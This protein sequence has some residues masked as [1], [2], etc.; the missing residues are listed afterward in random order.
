MPLAPLDQ[1][2]VAKGVAHGRSQAFPAIN[3]E[4]EP[5]RTGEAPLL[6]LLEKGREHGL[7]FGSCFHKPQDVFLTRE[8]DPDRH[9]HRHIS[10]GLSIEKN[11]KNIQLAQVAFLQSLELFGAGLGKAPRHR[12]TRQANRPEDRGRRG[13]IVPAGNPIEHPLQEDLIQVAR[14]AEMRQTL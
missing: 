5:L 14:P 1:R 12:G 2:G 10:K 8:R 7:V 4:Q 9:H 13:L 11:G 6:Q 3:D